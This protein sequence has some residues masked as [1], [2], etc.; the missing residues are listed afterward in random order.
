MKLSHLHILNYRGLRD[1]SIPQVWQMATGEAG[2]FYA[3]L[4]LK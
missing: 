4:F 2:R 3:D 1:V